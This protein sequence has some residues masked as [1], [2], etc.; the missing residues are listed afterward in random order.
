MNTIRNTTAALFS[1]GILALG[2]AACERQETPAKT[3]AD[4]AGA[5]AEGAKDVAK[6]LS[7]ASDHTAT[8]QKD[9]DKASAELAHQTATGNHDVAVAQA[10]ATHKV[11]IQRCG[12]MS[13]DA[14]TACTKQADADLAYAKLGANATERATDPKR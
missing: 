9:A 13:G 5:R 11:S 14:L 7:T 4:V 6:E 8:A 12:A 2:I 10:E 1:L 3:A